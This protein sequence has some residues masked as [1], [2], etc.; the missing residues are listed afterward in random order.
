MLKILFFADDKIGLNTLKHLI[1]QNKYNLI[2]I[3][4][5]IEPRKEKEF[6]N[7]ANKHNVNIFRPKNINSKDF[8]E[9]VSKLSPDLNLCV[10]HNQIFKKELIGIA[11][12]GTINMHCGLLPNYRGGG[13]IYGAVINNE[14]HFGQTIHFVDEGIDT[15]D[16]IIQDTLTIGPNDNM[17]VLMS[18]SVKNAPK[19]AMRAI[20]LI[21]NDE[22]VRQPQAQV[23][24]SYFPKKPDDDEI[25]DW[26]ES[27]LLIYNKIRARN[28]GPMNATYVGN[29]K[30]IIQTALLTNMPDYT[31]P[32]G[33]VIGVKKDVGVMVKTGDNALLVKHVML[34]GDMDTRIAKFKIGTTFLFNW[35]HK[36]LELIDKYKKLEERL[37]I[38]EQ[39]L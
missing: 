8:L 34:E 30:V 5:R 27:S 14:K 12:L 29:K 18:R 15:G 25:I 23:L 17:G 9:V 2:G 36:Y 22:Y 16:I 39:Q 4:L 21:E 31:G 13:G 3:V 24:G 20:D 11:R 10:N 26:S 7:I 32:V 35:Q 38:L 1:Y 33:Q 6:V 28:P 37:E 19:L